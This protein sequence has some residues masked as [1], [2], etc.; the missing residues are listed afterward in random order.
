MPSIC[1]KVEKVP[2]QGGGH[3]WIYSG[4]RQESSRKRETAIPDHA[5]QQR[6]VVGSTALAGKN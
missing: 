6:V 2:H 4:P 5:H 1:L 3:E